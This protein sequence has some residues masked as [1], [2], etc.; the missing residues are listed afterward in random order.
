MDRFVCLC[1]STLLP[2]VARLPLS[3]SLAWF[4]NRFKRM[5]LLK[6]TI[7]CLPPAGLQSNAVIM[8]NMLTIISVIKM[9]MVNWV[10]ERTNLWTKFFKLFNRSVARKFCVRNIIYSEFDKIFLE[11]L[12][13]WRIWI[14]NFLNFYWMSKINFFNVLVHFQVLPTS[15]DNGKDSTTNWTTRQ[16]V[17]LTLHRAITPGM[18]RLSVIHPLRKRSLCLNTAI[19]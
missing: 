11:E 13:N 14:S 3:L 5:I 15:L 6:D 8:V 1:V 10:Y 2:R 19:T 17:S 18:W 7:E 9:E 4:T 12:E 16:R